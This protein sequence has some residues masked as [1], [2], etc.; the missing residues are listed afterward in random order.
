[1]ISP[2]PMLLLLADLP[3][4]VSPKPASPTSKRGVGLAVKEL[5]STGKLSDPEM[6]LKQS[7][8]E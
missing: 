4:N 8:P 3:S 6:K 2:L 5:C 1:M 7:L